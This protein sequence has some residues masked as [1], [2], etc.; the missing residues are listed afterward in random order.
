MLDT[1][2]KEIRTGDFV[3]VSGAYFKNS[4]GLYL[5]TSASDA[6]DYC[7]DSVYMHKVKKNGEMCLNGSTSLPMGY[8]CSDRE[9]NRAAREHDSENLKYEVTDGIPT[10]HAAEHFKKKAAE[11]A[12]RAENN[13]R[14]GWEG[15]AE[16]MSR[17]VDYYSAVADRLSAT[18][19]QPK[20]KAPEHGIKFYWNGIKV[21]GGRLIPCYYSI[22]DSGD[23]ISIYARDYKD[24]PREYFTVVNNTDSM[25]DYFEDDRTAVT[26]E[27]PLYK[28]AR[29]AAWK[30]RVKDIPKSIERD[31]KELEGREPWRG[32]FD[33]VRQRIEQNEKYL[34]EFAKMKDPGQPTEADIKAVADLK[35]AQESARLAAEHAAQLAAREEHLRKISEGR[36]YIEQIAEQH[37]LVEG[38]PKVTIGFSESPCLYSLSHGANNVFSVAA[39]EIILKHY[40]EL[41]HAE[42]NGYEK[43]DFLIEWTDETSEENS[44]EGRYD[45]GDGDGG[46]IEHIRSLG[47]WYRTHDQH[48]GKELAEPPAE[49]SEQ[50][51]IADFLEQYKDGGRIIK[52]EVDPKIIDLMEV[53][54]QREAEQAKQNAQEWEQ[55][56]AAVEMLTDEQLEA[57]IYCID[58]QDKEKIDVAR[59]FLQELN[60]RDKNKAFEVF[61]KW[62]MG[63]GA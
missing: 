38:Q 29:Y 58:P 34:A 47:R 3:K 12:D 17:W 59:F 14:R 55:I 16:K 25:T 36:H 41:H 15:E 62:K 39:A 31:K 1:N 63:E 33:S 20:E 26:P 18:A 24:L 54:R 4:N 21:D 2:N 42:H 50:E 49:L 35:T 61:R 60:S 23:G 48:T 22:H 11:Y 10:Y 9:K 57:A 13:R 5:V 56:F 32:H 19:E 28:Y 52:I 46:M 53:R 27:H 30:A 7:G 40:D 45:L 51:Q 37:P 43:T 8:Y 44:Y 6:P